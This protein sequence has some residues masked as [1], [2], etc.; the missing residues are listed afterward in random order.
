MTAVEQFIARRG[1][2]RENAEPAERID[3]IVGAQQGG[4]NGVA[5]DAVEAIAARHIVA[6]QHG[7]VTVLAVVD[8]GAITVEAGD[9]G[10]LRLEMDRDAG[11]EI[12]RDHVLHCFLLPVDIDAAAGQRVDVDAMAL[13]LEDEF[14]AVMHHGFAMQTLAHAGFGDEIHRALLEQAGAHAALHIGAAARFQHHAGNPGEMQKPCEQ[15]SCG[16]CANDSDL[17]MHRCLRLAGAHAPWAALVR[18]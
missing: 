17:R 5:A 9:G 8:R 14:D 4:R 12:H 2:I 10:C 18:A 7:L 3:A 15:E 11:G 16:T 13:A 6:G 1:R